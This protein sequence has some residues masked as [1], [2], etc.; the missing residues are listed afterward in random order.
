MKLQDAK[1]LQQAG[2]LTDVAARRSPC[3]EGWILL[4]ATQRGHYEVLER[5][6]GGERV[7][8]TLDAIASV[9]EELGRATFNVQFA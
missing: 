2:A 3:H 5:F 7:F 1:L 8:Q 6:R 9:V 4:L